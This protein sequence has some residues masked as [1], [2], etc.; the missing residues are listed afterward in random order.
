M[1]IYLRLKWGK[2][3]LRVGKNSFNK[4]VKQGKTP[5]RVGKNS[6]NKL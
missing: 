6:F 1:Y 2:T 5:L 3:P 4:I